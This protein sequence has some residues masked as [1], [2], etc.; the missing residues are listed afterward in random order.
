MVRP[1][2]LRGCIPVPQD[3]EVES[4]VEACPSDIGVRPDPVVI[5]WLGRVEDE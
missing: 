3:S 2:V 4:P 5:D 1:R